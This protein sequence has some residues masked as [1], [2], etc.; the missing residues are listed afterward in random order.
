MAELY[1]NALI[2]IEAEPSSIPW[3]KVFT[4]DQCREFSECSAETRAEVW[5]VLHILEKGMLSYYKP[6]KINLASFAN[7]LPVVHW[8]VMARFENDT[9]FPEPMW[10]LQQRDNQLSFEPLSDFI[11]TV[12]EEL[13]QS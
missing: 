2:R 6:T 3:L 10:G 5:R 13:E 12:R 7:Y 1:R 8:H 9:H 4:L 11:S